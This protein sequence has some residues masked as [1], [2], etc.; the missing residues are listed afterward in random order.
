VIASEDHAINPELE[1]RMAKRANAKTTTLKSS[2]VA[3]LSKPKDV[4]AV[5]VDAAKSVSK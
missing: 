4:L 2:H 5:I 1:M 3:M